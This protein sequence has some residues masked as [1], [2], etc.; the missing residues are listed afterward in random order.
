MGSFMLHNCSFTTCM[1]SATHH[2]RSPFHCHNSKIL[3]G[4]ICQ[5]LAR[6]RLAHT[7]ISSIIYFSVSDTTHQLHLTSLVQNQ[8]SQQLNI[9]RSFHST[10]AQSTGVITINRW[11][12]VLDSKTLLHPKQSADPTLIP[13]LLNRRRSR[14]GVNF[15]YLSMQPAHGN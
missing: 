8:V 15:N 12:N 11:T 10:M 3:H 7:V 13:S 2:R 14:D 1:N 5:M 9:A 6:T 4:E